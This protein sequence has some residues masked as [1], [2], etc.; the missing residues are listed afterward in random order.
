MPARP[1]AVRAPARLVVSADFERVLGERSRSTTAHF[2]VHHLD[3][4]PSRPTPR[5]ARPG[6][7]E[8]S[9]NEDPAGT[10]PVEDFSPAALPAGSA[11]VGAVVP[12]R[13]AKRAATRSLLKRQIY[14]ATA[15]HRSRLAPGLWIVRLRAPFDPAHFVSAASAALRRA[16]RS[17]L[18]A[19]LS[20]ATAVHR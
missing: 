20:A 13:Y 2:A 16:A 12:K 17:E 19:L 14:A 8:L 18:D 9:T 15:R 5:R 1:P 4:P 6:P 11:W 10:F 3:S 7:T